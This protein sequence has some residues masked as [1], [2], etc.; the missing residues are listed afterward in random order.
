M[1]FKAALTII[2]NVNA[3]SNLLR[4]TLTVKP[5]ITKPKRNIT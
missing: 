4:V 5:V 3:G 1:N 2:F